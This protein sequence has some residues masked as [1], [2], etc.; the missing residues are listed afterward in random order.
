[1]MLERLNNGANMLK[2]EFLNPWAFHC[3]RSPITPPSPSPSS[4]AIRGLRGRLEYP[5]ISYVRK[6][7]TPSYCVCSPLFELV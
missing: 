7:G 3:R 5:L 2:R 4:A 1:M 6:V